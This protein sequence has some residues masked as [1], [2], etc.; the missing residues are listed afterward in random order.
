M[1][2]AAKQ[3]WKRA[4]ALALVLS[5]ALSLCFTTTFAADE[6]DAAG[7]EETTVYEVICGKQ[8]HLH[9]SEPGGSPSSSR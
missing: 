7:P 8:A 1:R 5:L 4:I 3:Y 6:D 9:G 2:S